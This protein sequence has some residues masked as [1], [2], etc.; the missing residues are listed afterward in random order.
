VGAGAICGFALRQTA[1][2]AC[3]VE[4][5]I[6]AF[7]SRGLVIVVDSGERGLNS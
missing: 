5:A 2:A 3:E 1:L 6:S 7:L 4:E